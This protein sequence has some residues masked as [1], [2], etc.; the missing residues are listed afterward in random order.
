MKD[1]VKE[2]MQAE[3]QFDLSSHPAVILIIGVNG[4]GKTTSIAKLAHY[5]RDAGKTVLL[6]AGD[7]FRAAA[8]GAAWRVGP[9]RGMVRHQRRRRGV[10]CGAVCRGKRLVC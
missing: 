1:I 7:T 10:R 4:V 8:S 5:Y 2:H 3:R 9:A 6:A